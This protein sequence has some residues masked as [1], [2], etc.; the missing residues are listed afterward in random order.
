LEHSLA[1]TSIKGRREEVS[2]R[3]ISTLGFK[4][5]FLRGA[6]RGGRIVSLRGEADDG[7]MK[8]NEPA[9]VWIRLCG[10]VIALSLLLAAGCVSR[11]K[12]TG[13]LTLFDGQLFS[14]W[15]LGPGAVDAFSLADG[16][17]I[18]RPGAQGQMLTERQYGDFILRFD[19]RA[20]EGGQAGLVMRAPMEGDPRVLGWEM[21]LGPGPFP[22]DR[23]SMG[24]HGTL[25]GVA[26]ATGSQRGYYRPGDGWN[27]QEV[28][29][30]GRR[31]RSVMNGREILNVDLNQL[32]N[33]E[34]LLRH[35]GLVRDR[36]HLGLVNRG[37]R[38]ELRNIRIRELASGTPVNL[39]PA[40]FEALFDGRT[41]RNWQGLVD[42]PTRAKLSAGDYLV[43]QIRADH[44]ML[45]NWRVE[46][47]ALVYRGN[48]FDNLC[49]IR[50]FGDI[51]LWLD[52]KIE[53]GSDSGV[54]LRGTPQVQIWDQPVGSGGL[55]NN[56]R[57]VRDPLRQADRYP[58]TWNRFR[59]VMVGER[60]TVWLNDELVVYDTVMENYW[61]PGQPIPGRGP[62]E[63][64]AH[65][66]PVWFRNV[67][68]RE[69]RRSAVDAQRE[70]N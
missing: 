9:G 55:F 54:Y 68:V 70:E 7:R 36:G 19:F 46:E 1:P 24:G 29:V 60:V 47:G 5:G 15:K 8:T 40:G 20:E 39:A 48:G 51:E 65:E 45:S 50:Q 10:G 67:F 16:S 30:R 37:G 18:C 35:P 12:E 2:F 52:W 53:R 31:V 59:I 57:H 32:P 58:G 69:L 14:A 43:E 28:V 21:Q 22:E 11:P 34:V 26:G 25:V 49:T 38:V 64:Q 27:E 23:G 56:K 33:P 44:V 62:I 41:F 4:T 17:L 66:T 6:E 3:R 63:L 61:D 42:P 13:F